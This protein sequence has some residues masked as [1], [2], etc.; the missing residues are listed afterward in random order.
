MDLVGVESLARMHGKIIDERTLGV[1]LVVVVHRW[2]VS[3]LG[4]EC[5]YCSV[6][7]SCII[8]VMDV[9]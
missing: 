4:S 9:G 2:V 7:G 3:E 6:L 8:I 1:A 5:C